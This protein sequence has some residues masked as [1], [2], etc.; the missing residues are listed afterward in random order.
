MRTRTRIIGICAF[1]TQPVPSVCILSFG[2]NV[3]TEME[4]SPWGTEKGQLAALVSSLSDKMP[5]RKNFGK[6]RLS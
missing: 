2:G 1:R 3:Y 4:R 5:K 6:K